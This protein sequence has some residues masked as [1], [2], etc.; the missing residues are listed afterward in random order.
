MKNTIRNIILYIR[1]YSDYNDWLTYYN[2]HTWVE[3]WSKFFRDI[4]EVDEENA[5]SIEISLLKENITEDALD[6][7]Q[8]NVSLLRVSAFL[9]I[10]EKQE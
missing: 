10:I 2:K 6:T 3:A 9:I 4:A 1:K 8:T 5:K 7:I